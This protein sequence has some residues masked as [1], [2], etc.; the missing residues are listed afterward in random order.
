MF[1]GISEGLSPP[2]E[3]GEVQTIQYTAKIIYINTIGLIGQDR[4]HEFKD[5]LREITPGVIGIV[6]AKMKKK[7]LNRR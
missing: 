5:C 6:Q 3:E 1:R 7:K 4:K 2:F